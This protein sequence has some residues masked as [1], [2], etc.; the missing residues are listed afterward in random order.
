MNVEI[1]NPEKYKLTL[2]VLSLLSLI[3]GT[4]A[5][6]VGDIALPFAAATLAA[7]MLFEK[8]RVLSFAIPVAIVLVNLVLDMLRGGYYSVV[9][10]ETVIVAFLVFFMFAKRRPKAE[11]VIAVTV[12][13]SVFSFVSLVLTACY[14]VGEFSWNAVTSFYGEIY[15]QLR[16]LLVERVREFYE[17]LTE[18]GGAQISFSESDV[19]AIL[20]SI[21]AVLP[22]IIVVLGFTVGGITFKLFG[23][24]VYRNVRDRF[25]ILTWRFRVTAVF[26]YFYVALLVI[27]FFV[28]GM[29]D[30]ITLAVENLYN[31]FLYVFAYIGFVYVYRLLTRMRSR[32]F[33]LTVLIFAVLM[34]STMAATVLSVAGAFF[35]IQEGK[36]TG[37][38]ENN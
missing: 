19:T 34:F 15:D 21:V 5:A 31:I 32:G 16:L 22:S 18:S 33:A 29:G 35:T 2:T 24:I 26:A 12:V 37:S 30:A 17:S 10:L 14:S 25:P 28:G 6:F 1:K 7:L 38:K 20:D 9:A 3:F 11:C 23:A 13:I 8:R 4:I 36:N 27:S